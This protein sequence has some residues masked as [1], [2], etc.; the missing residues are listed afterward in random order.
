MPV[1][2][3]P[4][5]DTELFICLNGTHTDWLDPIMRTL[6]STTFWIPLYLLLAALMIRKKQWLGVIAIA[7]VGISFG[8]ADQLSVILFK[9]VF[10]RLRPCHEVYLQ[11]IIHSIEPCGGQYGFISNHAANTFCLATFISLFFRNRYIGWSIFIWAAAVSYSRIYVGKHYPLD[12]V[13]GAMFGILC[14]LIGYWAYRKAVAFY[15]RYKQ[16]R[17]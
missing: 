13:C 12:I 9:N 16:N 5:W 1:L 15:I 3:F 11:T 17:V 6:S 10:Q 4:A 8:L 14:A 7:F 2:S